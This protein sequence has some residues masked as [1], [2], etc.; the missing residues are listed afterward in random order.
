VE[1]ETIE[2]VMGHASR[3]KARPG[4]SDQV[5]EAL[6]VETR[7][8]MTNL[9]HAEVGE[10]LHARRNEEGLLGEDRGAR[11]GEVCLDQ[12][13]EPLPPR[14]VPPSTMNIVDWWHM[15]GGKRLMG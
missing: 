4:R 5:K 8:D 13:I 12:R 3:S 7:A 10:P 14:A 1:N 9:G 11:G 2:I 15:Y 6:D